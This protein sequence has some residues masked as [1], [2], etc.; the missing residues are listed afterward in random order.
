LLLVTASLGTY[1]KQHHRRSGRCQAKGS[2]TL[3]RLT[4][5]RIARIGRFTGS[6]GV[7]TQRTVQRA[8]FAGNPPTCQVPA[9]G[10]HAGLKH[11]LGT[12]GCLSTPGLKR[13]M[14]GD[15][16]PELFAQRFLF[17]SV[18]RMSRAASPLAGRKGG[19]KGVMEGMNEGDARKFSVMFTTQELQQSFCLPPARKGVSFQREAPGW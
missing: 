15:L 6:A 19:R 3:K 2:P 8:T 9:S 13:G 14:T 1:V 7:Q 18:T 10:T 12:L 17:L 4:E 11:V 5:A 16:G